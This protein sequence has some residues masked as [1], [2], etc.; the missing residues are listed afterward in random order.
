MGK[1]PPYVDILK[2]REDRAAVCKIRISAHQ[3]MIERG[4][5]LNIPR[6]ERYCPLCNSNK[7][8][9]EEHFLLQRKSFNTQRTIFDGKISNILDNKNIDNVSHKK[10]FLLNNNS[11][12][13]LPLSYQTV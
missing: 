7:I 1:R 12:T 8:E 11:Y 9:N 10:S 4:R 6:N 2:N 3:L 13:I 5:H